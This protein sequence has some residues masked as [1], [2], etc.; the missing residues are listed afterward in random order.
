MHRPTAVVPD[1]QFPLYKG[2]NSPSKSCFVILLLK[3]E[4]TLMMDFL[5]LVLSFKKII[6]SGWQP[7]DPALS[8]G[9]SRKQDISVCVASVLTIPFFPFFFKRV[10]RDS[11]DFMKVQHCQSSTYSQPVT[12]R[13]RERKKE[14]KKKA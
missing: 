4:K 8:E 3:F 10:S 2:R 12:R 11:S 1:V 14:E 6:A 5:S 13:E 7:K 9:G